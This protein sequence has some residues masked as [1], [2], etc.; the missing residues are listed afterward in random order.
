MRQR[1]NYK[2]LI[3]TFK[4]L[5]GLAPTYLEELMKRTPM[6]RTRSNGNNDLVIPAIKHKSF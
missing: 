5:N 1:I 2:V 6:K 4:S 3:L